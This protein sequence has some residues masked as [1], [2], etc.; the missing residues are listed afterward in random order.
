MPSLPGFASLC[1]SEV[2]PGGNPSGESLGERLL[3]EC[4]E[5]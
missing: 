4:G 2:N 1:G 5:G 3:D